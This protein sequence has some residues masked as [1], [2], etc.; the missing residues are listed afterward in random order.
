MQGTS[1][2]TPY[3]TDGC[4]AELPYFEQIA[5]E[6]AESVSVVAIHTH[7]VIDTAPAYIGSNYHDASVIF[8]KDYPIDDQGLV[9]GY[10]SALGGRGTYPYTVVLDENGIIVKI[11]VSSVTYDDLKQIVDQ[12]LSK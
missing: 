9:G 6:Y 8:A 2:D 5:K 1:K 10:Y 11:F 3:G 7:L 12:T 4:C